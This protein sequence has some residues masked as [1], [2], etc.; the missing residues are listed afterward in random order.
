MTDSLRHVFDDAAE[1][2]DAARPSYPEALFDDLAAL[3]GLR[4]GDRLLEVGCATGKATRPLLERGFR[5]VCIELGPRLAAQGRRNLSGLDCEVHTAA[6]EE[7][8]G[9]PGSF[10]LVYAAT[11]WHWIDPGVGFQKSH[12]LLRPDGHIALWGASHAFPAGFDSFF[13]E[14]QTVYDE[15]GESHPGEWPPPAPE[16]TPDDSAAIEASGLF[17]DVQVRRYVWELS[18]TA[19]EYIALLDTFSGH[20]AMGSEKRARLD[21]EIRRRLEDR[22][23]GRLRRH[24]QATLHVARRLDM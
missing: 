13:T 9:E 4:P 15:L 14:I 16:E 2:Y 24:W 18:Y 19:D 5:V 22:P 8:E 7:W 21:A 6:F 3:A 10:D 11:A 20:I 17:G 12:R 23:D 1:L